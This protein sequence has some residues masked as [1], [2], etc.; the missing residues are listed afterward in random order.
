MSNNHKQ[1][2]I[3]GA[4]TSS[5]GI[6]LAKAIGLLYAS[7]FSIM[8][9]ES[10]MVFYGNAYALYDIILNLCTAGIPFAIASMIA[11]YNDKENYKTILVINR[12]AKTILIITGCISAIIMIIVA[13]PL[14]KFILGQS[15]PIQDIKMQQVTF[16]Y[17][18]IAL[19][20]VPLL[21][22]SRGL[23][24]GFK[25]MK[26]YSFTQ[27]LE[28]LVRVIF[29]LV[30]SYILLYIF[31][32][33]KIYAVY[34][35]ILA[36]S[37]AAIVTQIYL[38]KQTNTK[39]KVIKELAKTQVVKPIKEKVLFK[40]ILYFGLPYLLIVLL[41]NSMSIVN[42][43]FFL[44]I[45]ENT[46][47]EYTQSKL[48][49]GIMQFNATKIIS[50]P[51][52]LA[53]GFSAGMVPYLT[54]AFENDDRRLL[55]NNILDILEV[56]TFIALP[57]TF[58]LIGLAKPIYSLMYGNANIE[59]G[60]SILAYSSLVAIVGTI[61]PICTSILT[62][63]RMRKNVI[64]YLLITF[65]SKL[66]LFIPLV[67]FLNYKGAIFS[68]VISSLVCIIL[69]IRNIA[70]K[71]NISFKNYIIRLIKMLLGLISMNGVFSLLNIFISF[72]LDNKLN[73]LFLLVIYGSLGLLGYLITTAVFNIPQRI[74]RKLFK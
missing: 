3:L 52:V 1:S 39:L 21:S 37:I 24:Q 40:E 67:L 45:M 9:S 58:C 10:N 36:A 50:I 64:I 6:F 19:A 29:L 27:V 22:G 17:L 61:S 74:L 66:V 72:N 11:K 33:D 35:G 54:V 55:K 62:T 71:Y 28:Q 63:L 42:S 49:L 12:L 57:L 20:T 31:K 44:P 46:S 26:L 18:A 68:S 8:A 73:I 70:N 34:M 51:Q 13:F 32:F 47:I 7:P 25:N 59:L 56:V 69:C 30:A 65:I 2:L 53:L 15:A 41:G 60:S 48:M 43:M 14:S 16:L 4:L 38:I 5:F 23:F